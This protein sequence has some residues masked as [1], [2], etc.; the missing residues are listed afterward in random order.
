MT[1]T[2]DTTTVLRGSVSGLIPHPTTAVALPQVILG[3][4]LMKHQLTPI[5]VAQNTQSG[6][7]R[8][9]SSIP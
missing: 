2:Y 9:P 1:V 3:H 8:D 6:T 7:T 4:E 5:L